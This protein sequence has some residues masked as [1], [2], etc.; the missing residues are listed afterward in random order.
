MYFTRPGVLP[1]LEISAYE[2]PLCC[3]EG[4]LLR[5]AVSRSRNFGTVGVPRSKIGKGALQT[6]SPY[7]AGAGQHHASQNT[8][9]LISLSAGQR[10]FLRFRLEGTKALVQKRANSLVPC[11][12]RVAA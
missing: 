10:D 11:D 8:V 12:I 5:D 9:P 3:V 1:W 2:R 4:R 6:H 7:L